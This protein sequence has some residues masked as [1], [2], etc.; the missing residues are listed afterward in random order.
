VP[1]H[2][3]PLNW[4]WANYF[5]PESQIKVLIVLIKELLKG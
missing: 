5:W 3:Y 4:W 1:P 2:P